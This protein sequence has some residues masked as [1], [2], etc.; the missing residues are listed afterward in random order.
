MK[1]KSLIRASRIAL[2]AAG[3][4]IMAP[5]K[6]ADTMGGSGNPGVPPIVDET[7]LVSLGGNTRPEAVAQNDRGPVADSMVLPHM[8]LLLKRT[9]GA[10]AALEGFIAGLYD[11]NWASYHRW[12][13]ARRFG[14]AFG[15]PPARIAAVVGWLDDH[16]FQVNAVSDGRTIIDFSGTA[17]Q[18]REAFHSEI[19]HLD[20]GG[21]PHIANMS[22]PQIPAA[23]ADVVE[24]IV[25]LHDFR[26]HTNFKTR[27]A[28]TFTGGNGEGY[29]AVVPADLAKIYNLTPLF[30]AGI[31]GRGQSIVVIED[32]DVYSKTDW[33]DFRK[34]FGLA[35]YKSGSF[36]LTHPKL[37]GG[38]NNCADPGVLGGNESEA[39]L[40]AEWASAAAPDAAI[41]LAACADTVNGFGGLIALQNLVNSSTP[42]TIVSISYGEC[43]AANGAAGNAAY[44]SIYQQAVTEGISIFVSS[45]DEGAASC[46]ADLQNA[47]HGIGVSA[48]ASTP[49]NM[50]VGGTDFGDTYAKSNDTYWSGT[51]RKD[52]GQHRRTFQKF[53]GIILAQVS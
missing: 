14:A 13:S 25:S 32:T 41:Q 26:P 45:G 2:A 6:G 9:A 20:A 15:P 39:E 21:T 44:N 11:Q 52:Y 24:G 50:S 47:S 10:K 18:V 31:T 1:Q 53:P 5:A 49:Y 12:I 37:P 7:Q 51:N 34:T 8:Q 16:G 38:R 23:L 46:D 17:G 29:E 33:T 35:K 3:L 30:K 19:H 43:E 22:D 40:D 42:P 36:E 28:Y 27:P 4:A 48:F